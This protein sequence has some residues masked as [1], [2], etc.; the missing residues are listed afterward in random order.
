MSAKKLCPSARPDM[1]GAKIIGVVR[2]DHETPAV[3]YFAEA[4]DVTA[5]LLRLAAPVEPMEIYRF[6]ADCQEGA[7]SHWA[8]SECSLI[9]RVADLVPAASLVLPPC[10]IRPECRW[11]AQRRAAACRRCPEVVTSNQDPSDAMR[12]ASTPPESTNANA[13]ANAPEVESNA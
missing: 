2:H 7:C 13:N 3:D 5:E 6:A 12:A 4:V 1:P 10:G 11:F 9:E 8:R